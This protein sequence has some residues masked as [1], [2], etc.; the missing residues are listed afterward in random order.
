MPRISPRRSP[1]RAQWLK[2]M[3]YCKTKILTLIAGAFF[4]GLFSGC[5]T[6]ASTEITLE[7]AFTSA[8]FVKRLNENGKC[9]AFQKQNPREE[10]ALDFA[11]KSESEFAFNGLSLRKVDLLDSNTPGCQS[12]IAYSG[13]NSIAII[14]VMPSLSGRPSDYVL[15]VDYN[16]YG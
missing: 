7:R 10:Y 12:F 16:V 15:L 11:L 14:S 6:G 13:V 9:F 8:G 3:L 4:I 1:S 2:R 5:A